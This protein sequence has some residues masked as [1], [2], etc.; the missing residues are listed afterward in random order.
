MLHPQA[1]I[2]ELDELFEG[3]A[4]ELEGVVREGEEIKIRRAEKTL[5]KKRVEKE[6]KEVRVKQRRA[7]TSIEAESR[8]KAA[9]QQKMEDLVKM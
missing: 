4:S 6:V 1:K 8:E 7:R 2:G 5:E 9:L 3:V